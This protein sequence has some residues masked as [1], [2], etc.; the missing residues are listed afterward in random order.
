MPWKLEHGFVEFL[1]VPVDGKALQVN[2]RNIIY[3]N[4]GK[5]HD[6]LSSPR[7]MNQNVVSARMVMKSQ[8]I[9]TESVSCSYRLSDAAFWLN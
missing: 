9:N 3:L 2:I 4:C 5:D 6:T 8:P 7:Q 1:S